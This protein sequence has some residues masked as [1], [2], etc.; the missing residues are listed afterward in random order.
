MTPPPR[1]I[2]TNPVTVMPRAAAASTRSRATCWRVVVG[3]S[4]PDHV[5][6]FSFLAEDDDHDQAGRRIEDRGHSLDEWDYAIAPRSPAYAE[7]LASYV[8]KYTAVS[9][10]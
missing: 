10:T 3:G 2:N 6:P 7:E 9:S 4:S 1:A 5:P 8:T